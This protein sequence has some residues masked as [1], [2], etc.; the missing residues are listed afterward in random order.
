MIAVGSSQRALS[1]WASVAVGL[2]CLACGPADVVEI[3]GRRIVSAANRPV[4]TGLSTAQ[5][6]GASTTETQEAPLS[7]TLP[8][9]WQELQA[10]GM[11]LA[12]L[13]P[14]GHPDAECSLVILGG[15]GGGLV[16]NVNRWRQEQ[17]GLEPLAPGAVEQLPVMNL[18]GAGAARIE[19]NGTYTNMGSEPRSDWGL[20]GAI[21][22]SERFTIFVKMTGPAALVANETS[23]FEAFC[24]SL[25][26]QMPGQAGT[27]PP[28]L[29][30]GPVVQSQGAGATG[31]SRSGGS[32]GV[33]DFSLPDGWRERPPGGMRVVNLEA[34]ASAECYV[35]ELP[36]EAGGLKDNITRWC[37]QVGAQPLGDA[38][39]AALPT[40]R[41]LGED[42]PLLELLGEGQSSALLGVLLVRPEGSTFVKMLGPRDELLAERAGFIAFVESMERVQ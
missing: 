22:V 23:A 41:C 13:R 1:V 35:V 32:R 9:G 38:A 3:E 27:A 25:Q 28:T 14:A 6:F 29:G 37:G 34:G 16:A 5:R 15:S 8:P 42:C 19:L 20:L 17:M 26:V 40:I 33:F 18:L 12:N 21:L 11:R 4:R 24:G 30:S 31:A 2:A 7:W 39:V 36:G 10:S